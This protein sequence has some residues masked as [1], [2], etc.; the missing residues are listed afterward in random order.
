MALPLV[1]FANAVDKASCHAQDK[2]SDAQGRKREMSELG[3]RKK[4]V[5]N[6][7]KAFD[8]DMLCLQI[9]TY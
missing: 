3:P 4:I 8:C 1:S 2:T 7:V 6:S 5:L 9:L